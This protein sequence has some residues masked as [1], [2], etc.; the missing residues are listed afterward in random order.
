MKRLDSVDLFRLLA[1]IAVIA[2]HTEPFASQSA[3]MGDTFNLP[4]LIAQISRFA[5]P[6]FFIISGYFWGRKISETNSALYPSAKLAQ[7]ISIIFFIWTLIYAIPFSLA[8]FSQNSIVH[9][10][11]IIYCELVS[12]A[13]N[14]TTLFF[15]GTKPHLWFLP[16]LIC[17]IAISA[18]FVANNR[19]NELLTIAI[20]L[21]AFGLLA[22]SYAAT[23]IGVHI[24]FNT[25]NGPFFALL[26]FV[27]GYMLSQARQMPHW[28]ALGFISII[29][30]YTLQCI[31]LATLHNNYHTNLNQD[32]VIGTYFI[33]LGF[34]LCA[35]S[36]HKY[37]QVPSL[38]LL[39]R[40]TLGIYVA[41]FIFIDIFKS[42]DKLQSF[43]AW[44]II[45]IILVFAFS[46]IT[47]FLLKMY[48]ITR[49]I[50]V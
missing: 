8:V 15:Q 35:L 24:P 13:T 18:I 3:P 30:G 40:N 34:S 29:F 14:P 32:F 17:C 36:N 21:Y 31:E 39:G 28:P 37:F 46:L 19:K 38:A 5:V 6:F 23:P 49:H 48:R 26:P 45:Y 20:V 44:D 25:R 2:L 7:R 11:K 12:A 47:T 43:F 16:A 41:H 33:G 10:I 1:I 27:S 4:T 22:K 9:L 42:I 50:V